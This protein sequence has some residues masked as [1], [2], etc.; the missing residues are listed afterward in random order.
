MASLVA[1]PS[2]LVIE[3]AA[4]QL[5]REG[6]LRFVDELLRLLAPSV[7][8]GTLGVR[9]LSLDEHAEIEA[10]KAWAG[11]FQ[12]D[13]VLLLGHGSPAG[14]QA[15]HDAPMSWAEVGDALA[16][17]RPRVVMGVSCFAGLTGVVDELFRRVPTLEVVLGSP[18]PTNTA[19]WI[20]AVV[21]FLVTT[22]GGRIPAE[23]SALATFYN[24]MLTRGVVFRRTREG[25]SSTPAHHRLGQD[26]LGMLAALAL[27]IYGDDFLT[28][29]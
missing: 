26:L 19:Q 20:P 29:A 6:H 2:L 1:H 15:A 5:R 9:R 17:V 7:K 18:A 28:A 21:E 14:F 10:A 27:D 8:Q 3:G 13:G 16:P 22:Y 25:L 4:A 12:Y 24:A 11:F 23:L